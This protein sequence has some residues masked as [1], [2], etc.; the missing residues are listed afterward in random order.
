MCDFGLALTDVCTPAAATIKTGP[1]ANV[2]FSVIIH[3]SFFSCVH[4]A[5]LAAT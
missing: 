3:R 4:Y 1:P 2:R 5:C